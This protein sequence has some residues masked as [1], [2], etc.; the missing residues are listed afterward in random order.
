MIK[1]L[2]FDF[3]GVI[4]Q[5]DRARAVEAF[6]RLGLAEAD[7]ILD[8]YHQRGIFLDLETGKVSAEVYLQELGRMCGRTLSWDEVEAAW[9]AFVEPV[10]VRLLDFI[11]SLR[12]RYKV[13]L[14]SNTNPF[15]MNWARSPRLSSAGL[16]LD[17]Y[18]DRL[19]LSYQ[20]GRAKPDREI[21]EQMAA[22]GSFRPDES[23]FVDDS[24]T[25]LAA[26]R[27]LGFQTFCPL[28]EEGVGWIDR[29]AA[30]LDQKI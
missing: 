30:W 27:A 22:T 5:L 7:K 13:Y 29:F 28:P 26:S 11:A 23:V 10:S 14:L 24:E 1:N 20:M 6:R 19:F 12:P 3:G 15:I 25:N 17:A 18:F 16:P 2:I 9:L 21:Y 4:I 8:K